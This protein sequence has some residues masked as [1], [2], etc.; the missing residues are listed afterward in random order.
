MRTHTCTSKSAAGECE[1]VYNPSE[2]TTP[3]ESRT[4]TSQYPVSQLPLSPTQAKHYLAF[5]LRQLT[6]VIIKGYI[7]TYCHSVCIYYT[8]YCLQV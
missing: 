4:A 2:I 1:V 7:V 6:T 3:T 8:N 5:A